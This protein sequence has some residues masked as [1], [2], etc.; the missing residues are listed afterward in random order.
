MKFFRRTG[1]TSRHILLMFLMTALCLA[2]LS[3]TGPAGQSGPPG[4]AGPS[5]PQGSA[6][7]GKGASLV[8]VPNPVLKDT[9][10]VDIYGAGFTPGVRI[11]LGVKGVDKGKDLL[12]E[13]RIPGEAGTIDAQLPMTGFGGL[14][15]LN[16]KAGAYTVVAQAEDG[17]V[18]A[19]IPLVIAE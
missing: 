6:A 9:A 11:I 5:G 18:I 4:P 1:E 7:T 13:A 2:L 14:R 16:V 15:G 12:F 8:V 19:T 10:S 17:A 3:C